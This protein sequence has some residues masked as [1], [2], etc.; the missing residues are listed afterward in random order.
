MSFVGKRWVWGAEQV[1]EGEIIFEL[2]KP[3]SLDKE[4]FEVTSAVSSLKTV[5]TQT[6]LSD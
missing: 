5:H 1:A 6:K 2:N 4:D 3:L